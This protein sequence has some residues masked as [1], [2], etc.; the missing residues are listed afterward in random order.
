MKLIL[1][2]KNV[3]LRDT[4][5][6]HIERR[7]DAALGR[8]SHQ[9]RCVSITLDDV[10]GPRGGIDKCC[11]VVVTLGRGDGICA[12][13]TDAELAEAVG[14]AAERAARSIQRKLERRRRAKRTDRWSDANWEDGV[15]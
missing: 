12:D 14:E 5:R 8:F 7:L 2:G 6:E 4:L 11:R 13:A 15:D 1:S 3:K 10:N 9:I